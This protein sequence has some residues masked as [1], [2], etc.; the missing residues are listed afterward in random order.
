MRFFGLGR[1]GLASRVLLVIAATAW[2]IRTLRQLPDDLKEFRK[3]KFPEARWALVVNWSLTALVLAGL[4]VFTPGV[5]MEFVR[6]F[7]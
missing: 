2:C 6:L 5:V 1:Y 7:Q 4:V 3:T